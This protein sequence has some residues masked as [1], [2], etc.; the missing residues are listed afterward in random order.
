MSCAVLIDTT[1]VP[2]ARGEGSGS[3]RGGSQFQA[4]EES[5]LLSNCLQSLGMEFPGPE[6]GRPPSSCE[7][8]FMHFVVS[9]LLPHLSE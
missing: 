8:L 7:Y 5:C 6:S 2:S 4:P 9:L 1:G 3:F